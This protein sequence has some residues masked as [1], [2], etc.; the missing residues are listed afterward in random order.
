MNEKFGGF[1]SNYFGASYDEEVSE[2]WEAVISEI[3]VYFQGTVGGWS[4]FYCFKTWNDSSLENDAN[5]EV[6]DLLLKIDIQ[7]GADQSDIA[8]N[9][10]LNG[11]FRAV[12]VK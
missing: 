7:N 4:S 5:L 11:A 2:K 8:S 12:K 9:L 3:L 1:L 10:C 6:F